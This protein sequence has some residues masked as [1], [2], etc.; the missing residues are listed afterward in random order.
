MCNV[1]HFKA[2]LQDVCLSILLRQRGLCS[3]APKL[4]AFAC[5]ALDSCAFRSVLLDGG[6]PKELD[7]FLTFLEGLGSFGYTRNPW[8]EPPAA[9]LGER[10]NIAAV[11]SY[12]VDLYR[13]DRVVSRSLKVVLIGREGTGKTRCSQMS[14]NL[15]SPSWHDSRT[16]NLRVC[17]MSA[18]PC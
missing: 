4:S 3:S 10:R 5:T 2:G 11:R 13:E 9:V 7:D 17:C 18:S 8:V 16:G 6:I 12:Y 1:H 14:Q 15:V